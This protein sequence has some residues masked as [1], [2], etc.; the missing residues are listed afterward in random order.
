MPTLVSRALVGPA[1]G[2][3]GGGGGGHLHR[4]R[5]IDRGDGYLEGLRGALGVV[6][7]IV[8]R[9]AVVL[10]LHGNVCA[11]VLVSSKRVGERAVSRD[12]R[13]GREQAG[14]GVVGDDEAQPL[15]R[16]VGGASRDSASP[17]GLLSV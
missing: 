15:A 10:E 7:R 14:V 12:G 5:V 8:G 9:A 13:T 16:L 4:G 11:A 1:G 6:A 3:L 2:A 17:V